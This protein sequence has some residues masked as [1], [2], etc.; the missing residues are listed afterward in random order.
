MFRRREIIVE[1]QIFFFLIQR[2]QYDE[3]FDCA[4]TFS[5]SKQRLWVYKYSA[6]EYITVGGL[7]EFTLYFEVYLPISE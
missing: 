6:N 4:T 3:L 1:Y 7:K 2:K 5:V